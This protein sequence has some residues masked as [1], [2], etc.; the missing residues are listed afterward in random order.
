MQSVVVD[1]PETK[2]WGKPPTHSGQEKQVVAG[3]KI[4]TKQPEVGI[5][6]EHGKKKKKPSNKRSGEAKGD[7]DKVHKEKENT[8]NNKSK[9]RKDGGEEKHEPEPPKKPAWKKEVLSTKVW[10][11]YFIEDREGFFFFLFFFFF[12]VVV[13]LSVNRSLCVWVVCIALGV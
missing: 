10:F 12:F 7:L 4:D 11:K 2:A 9:D 3:H 13:Y 1:A 6:G 5:R 8:D